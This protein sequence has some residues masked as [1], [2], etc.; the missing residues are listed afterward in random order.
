VIDSKE[1]PQGKAKKLSNR[2]PLEAKE[3]ATKYLWYNGAATFI[4]GKRLKRK[5]EEKGKA[6]KKER[7]EEPI[8]KTRN[9]LI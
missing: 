1:V 2:D 3:K 4:Y 9:V 6:K 5:S 7:R 8:K